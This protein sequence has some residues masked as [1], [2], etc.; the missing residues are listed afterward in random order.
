MDDDSYTTV[1]YTCVAIHVYLTFFFQ[2]H[3]GLHVLTTQNGLLL[4]NHQ[5]IFTQFSYDLT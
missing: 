1:H 4:I 2:L 3:V 5:T